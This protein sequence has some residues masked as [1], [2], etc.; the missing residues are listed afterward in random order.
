M[1]TYANTEKG[2]SSGCDGFQRQPRAATAAAGEVKD[3]DAWREGEQHY[4]FPRELVQPGKR[5]ALGGSSEQHGTGGQ[6][7]SS[8]RCIIPDVSNAQ[9]CR[10]FGIMAQRVTVSRQCPGG[11]LGQGSADE[12][13]ASLVS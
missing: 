9:D 2:V 10:K 5:G 12:C 3:G 4:P 8:F 1:Y 7:C 11:W 13:Q 6:C